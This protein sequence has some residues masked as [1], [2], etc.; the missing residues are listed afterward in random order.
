[1]RDTTVVL[2]LFF[3]S[4]TGHARQDTGARQVCSSLRGRVGETECSGRHGIDDFRA[5]AISDS[6]RRTRL[7]TKSSNT[8]TP[9][10]TISSLKHRRGPVRSDSTSSTKYPEGDSRSRVPEMVQALL[11]DRFA[12]KA[13][14]EVREGPIF[15]LVTVRSDGR[16]GERLRRTAVDCVAFQAKAAG[17]P[18]FIG[19]DGRPTCMLIASDRFIRGSSRTIR[20]LALSLASSG[21]ATSRGSHRTHRGLRFRSRMVA[22]D[23]TGGCPPPKLAH[24]RR[25]STTISP[26]SRPCGSSSGSN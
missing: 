19:P 13:H 6:E 3:T 18:Q 14:K 25:R 15:E 5:G 24:R 10:L 16:L 12:L 11:A 26:S 1:M 20:Q 17:T 2:L 21:W 7:S 9:S 23:Q 8:R 22:R 4:L